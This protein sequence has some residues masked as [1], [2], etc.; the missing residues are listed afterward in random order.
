MRQFGLLHDLTFYVFVNDVL[1]ARL[2]RAFRRHAA[3]RL[4]TARIWFEWRPRRRYRVALRIILNQIAALIWRVCFRYAL[5]IVGIQEVF[6][7]RLADE[8]AVEQPVHSRLY[9]GKQAL[10]KVIGD[11]SSVQ[12]QHIAD[13]LCYFFHGLLELLPEGQLTVVIDGYFVV[14]IPFVQEIAVLDVG[15]LM[16]LQE[17]RAILCGAIRYL[18]WPLRQHVLI[19]RLHYSCRTTIASDACSSVSNVTYAV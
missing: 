6:Q 5:R 8:A 17:V 9:A 1:H 11:V 2:A 19:D 16:L 12:S 15:A 4:R 7:L 18:E 14:N 13:V 3:L 10:F